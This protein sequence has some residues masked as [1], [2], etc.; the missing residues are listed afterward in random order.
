MV[1]P[2]AD[3]TTAILLTEGI[4]GPA[5][6]F[7]WHKGVELVASLRTMFD[8]PWLVGPGVP[9]RPLNVAVAPGEDFRP[10]GAR[11]A[12]AIAT[13]LLPLS[14]HH[15][16]PMFWIDAHRFPQV[17]VESLCLVAP[18]EAIAQR[19][20]KRFPI[21][22]KQETAAIVQSVRASRLLAKK[23]GEL[24][25]SGAS[26]CKSCACNRCTASPFR[27]RFGKAEVE[28]A[29]VGKIGGENEVEEPSLPLGSKRGKAAD[30]GATPVLGVEVDELPTAFGNEQGPIGQKGNGPRVIKSIGNGL[31]DDLWRG[32]GS[33]R[34]GER[35]A[36]GGKRGG[37]RHLR[38]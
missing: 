12:L 11:R 27:G 16:L 17:V 6:V 25:K 23:D 33:K 15:A 18:M 2:F 5:V 4:V 10:G 34:R 31:D 35:F 29:A 22:L 38:R 7:T 26:L 9:D 14:G 32:N 30:Q 36:R 21:G 3:R 24:T 20:Q 13:P 1:A 19:H 28:A 37:G 8:N